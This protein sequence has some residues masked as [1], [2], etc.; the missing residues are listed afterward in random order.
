MPTYDA[1][2][3]EVEEYW[4]LTKLD[5]GLVF[6]QMSYE[7]DLTGDPDAA[8]YGKYQISQ[9]DFENLQQD[10]LYKWDDSAKAVRLKNDSELTEQKREA[11]K[12][13]R[14]NYLAQS[15]F[16]LLDDAPVTAD[17]KAEWQ[18]YRQALRDLPSNT[19]DAQILGD[20]INWPTL[21]GSINAAT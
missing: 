10:W 16:Y 9:T 5:T 6:S 15:D 12:A 8:T 11:F 19:T 18:T 17:K 2:G 7:P 1:D 4:I 3:F 14:N 13:K 21:P 20:T